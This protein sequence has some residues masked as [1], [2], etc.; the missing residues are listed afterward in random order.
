MWYDMI[1]K[2]ECEYE[3]EYEYR[4]IISPDSPEYTVNSG[5]ELQKWQDN[6]NINSLNII[7]INR[8]NI[9]WIYFQ[10]IGP[11]NKKTILFLY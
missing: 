6:N 7:Q 1:E 10:T 5:K 3:Y 11:N 2:Y 8:N 4:S 9:I